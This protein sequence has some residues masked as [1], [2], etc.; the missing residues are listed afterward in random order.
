MA[1]SK[2]SDLTATAAALLT[3]EF[4]VNEAGTSKK[5]TLAQVQ[6]LLL[7][8]TT[9]GV[10]PLVFFIRQHS[11]YQLLNQGTVQ[12]LFNGSPN[13]AVQLPTGFYQFS[14][15]FALSAMS[16]TSGNAKFSI[17]NGTGTGAGFLFNYIGQDVGTAGVSNWNGGMA[18]SSG[19]PVSLAAGGVNTAMIA[20]MMGTFEVSGAGTFIPS[21]TLATAAAAVVAIGSYFSCSRLGA[22]TDVVMPASAW[23]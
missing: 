3:H 19:T 16:A 7:T 9:L 15:Q 6:T 23:S 2:V 4:P 1:D 14:C 21:I 17:E 13:G 5:E 11:T 12:P 8:D 22:A 18:A 20:N 10:V